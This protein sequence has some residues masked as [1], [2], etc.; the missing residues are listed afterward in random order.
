M[1]KENRKEAL[2]KVCWKNHCANFPKGAV[3]YDLPLQACYNDP[4]NNGLG[5]VE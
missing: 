5:K 4:T 1:A 3:T 2:Q